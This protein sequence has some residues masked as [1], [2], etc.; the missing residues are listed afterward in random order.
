MVECRLAEQAVRVARQRPGRRLL[1]LLLL[2]QLLELL[3]RVKRILQVGDGPLARI[4]RELR[5]LLLL[6]LRLR[7]AQLSHTVLMCNRHRCLGLGCL[8]VWL[9]SLTL[10][11]RGTLLFRG[12]RAMSGTVCQLLYGALG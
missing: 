2:S 8:L 9:H 3:Q 4:G 5:L 1:L 10:L 6:G 12:G 11:S 7:L